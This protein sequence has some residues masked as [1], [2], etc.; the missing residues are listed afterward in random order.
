MNE[1]DE[2]EFSERVEDIINDIMIEHDQA[3][4]NSFKDLTEKLKIPNKHLTNEYSAGEVAGV[5]YCIYILES[6]IERRRKEKV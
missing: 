4:I 1:F 2:Y 5:E 3:L 6:L